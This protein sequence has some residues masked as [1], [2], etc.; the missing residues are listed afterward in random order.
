MSMSGRLSRMSLF[1]FRR[2]WV[3]RSRRPADPAQE[4]HKQ[5]AILIPQKIV[6]ITFPVNG[7]VR[8]IRALR[9]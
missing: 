3:Y 6:A 1:S 9:D 4:V 8:N 5:D 2:S 7:L